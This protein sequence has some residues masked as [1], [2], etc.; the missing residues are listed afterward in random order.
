MAPR[1]ES[2]KMAT[3]ILVILILNVL[4]AGLA[5]AKTDDSTSD[6]LISLGGAIASVLAA[7]WL[8]FSSGLF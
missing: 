5:L 1:Q 4:D 8:Y 7:Q 2:E 6:R 3:L